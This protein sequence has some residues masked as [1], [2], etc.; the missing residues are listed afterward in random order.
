MRPMIISAEKK[1]AEYERKGEWVCSRG[2]L[3]SDIPWDS[4]TDGMGAEHRNWAASARRCVD[5]G[6]LGAHVWP[7]RT[8]F[9]PPTVL[10]L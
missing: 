10:L 6:H 2:R 5:Y 4:A 9:P 8:C 1:V 3:P 7:Q